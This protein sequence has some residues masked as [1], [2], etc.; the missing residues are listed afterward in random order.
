M[1]TQDDKEAT[2]AH[3][4]VHKSRYIPLLPGLSVLLVVALAI[5]FGATVLAYSSASHSTK[6]ILRTDIWQRVLAGYTIVSLVVAPSDPAVLYACGTPSQSSP[7]IPQSTS[8]NT[9][10]G[11]IDGGTTWRTLTNTSTDCQLV[12]NPAKSNDLYIIGLAGHVASNGEVP[13]VL[14]HSTDGGHSWSDIVPTFTTGTAQLSIEWHVQQLSMI[15]NHLFGIQVVPLGRLQ[16]IGQ[17]IGQPIIPPSSGTV[18]TRLDLSRL[19]E[20]SDG[21]HTWTI[22]DGNLDMSGQA[23]H[24]YAI[25]SSN[26]HTVYEL[27]GPQWFPYRIPT[28]PQDTP[29]GNMLTLYKTTDDGGTWT[30][31]LENVPYN[32]Q[33]LLARSVPSLVYIGGQTGTLPITGQDISPQPSTFLLN[34]SKDGGATWHTVEAP[35]GEPLVQDWFVNA[36]GQVFIETATNYYKPPI[37]PKGTPISTS[38]KQIQPVGN[39]VTSTQNVVA[40][41]VIAI[42]RY[43]ATRGTWSTMMKTPTSGKLIAVLDSTTRHQS[44]LW[45]LSDTN[46]THVLYREIV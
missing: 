26:S 39:A 46:N 42:Q 43:D 10:L 44:A 9:L 17:P 15:G 1:Q 16:P 7:S 25:S 19:V 28:T 14:R 31:L 2:Q 29:Y 5:G 6:P 45:F 22:F 34:V 11:S 35:A 38:T 23:T 36:D 30:K 20:S 4:T 37:S 41:E 40:D 8:S 32:S 21:G 13:T 27:V 12:V 24:A 33:V 18:V 3:T